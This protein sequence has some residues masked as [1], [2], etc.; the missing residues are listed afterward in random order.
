[1]S[2]PVPNLIGTTDHFA[3]LTC[4]A[5]YGEIVVELMNHEALPKHQG[6]K[7]LS[8]KAGDKSI[9]VSSITLDAFARD[10]FNYFL[11]DLNEEALPACTLEVLVSDSFS[12]QRND[13][14]RSFYEDICEDGGGLKEV[15]LVTELS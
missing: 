13:A 4:P 1:M 3:R 12:D 5:P 8:A 6:V 9:T 14:A 10:P 7:E 11:D 15:K 2:H